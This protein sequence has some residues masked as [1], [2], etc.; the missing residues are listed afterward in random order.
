MM[1]A[2]VGEKLK[3]AKKRANIMDDLSKKW[4]HAKAK[5]AFEKLHEVYT[6][7]IDNG[8]DPKNYKI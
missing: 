4:L 6:R 2:Q 5:W 1:T 8:Y 3:E 7:F